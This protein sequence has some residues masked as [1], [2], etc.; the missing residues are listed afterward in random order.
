M[1]AS[2]RIVTFRGRM[3]GQ[4]MAA[5]WD[6][7]EL[8]ESHHLHRRE[9]VRFFSIMGQ[10]G[11]MGKFEPFLRGFNEVKGDAGLLRGGGGDGS[12]FGLIFADALFECI[13][14]FCRAGREGGAENLQHRFD[15]L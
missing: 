12:A 11:R 13:Y 15:L 8:P 6:A 9:L 10:R 14:Y 7:S 2:V 1:I 5:N 3:R 4:S